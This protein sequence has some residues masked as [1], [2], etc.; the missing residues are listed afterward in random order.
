[1]SLVTVIIVNYQSG[2]LLNQTIQSLLCQSYDQFKLLIIDNA[3]TDGSC[4]G[5]PQDERFTLL[6]MEENLGF[7]KANNI[8]VLQATTP[9]LVFLNPDTIAHPDW[10][11]HLIQAT[12]SYPDID[13]F[14]SLQRDG[15]N[16]EICDG[17]GDVYHIAGFM[18][19]GYYQQTI[20]SWL[21]DGEV[22]SICA[23]AWMLR[24]EDFISCG[25]FDEDFFCYNEDVDLGFRMRLYGYKMMQCKDAEIIHMGSATTGRHSAFSVYHGVRNR[26]FVLIKNMPLPILIPVLPVYILLCCVDL[27]RQAKR[28]TLRHALRAHRGAF[29]M[30]PKMLKKRREIQ[31]QRSI[32]L[33]TLCR[34]FSYSPMALL[35]RRGKVLPFS[36][37]L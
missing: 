29:C 2:F 28:G 13:G 31:S 23:A 6:K 4:E 3:S 36:N 20:G 16:N 37:V 26:S 10:L 17:F 1:M 34:Y 24:R 5:L 32:T 14:G 30:L 12:S 35:K 21:Q 22:F 18:T 25:G 19:R 9:W 15:A 8:A 11:A 27:I 33:K 7:A